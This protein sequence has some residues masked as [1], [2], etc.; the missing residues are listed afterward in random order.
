MC[1]NSKIRLKD[2]RI[3]KTDAKN[4]LL[5]GSTE[6]ERFFENSFLL[7]DSVSIKDFTEDNI[8]FI[9]GM[10]GT[11][12]TALLR[13]LEIEIRKLFPNCITSF[14][15]FKSDITEDTRDEFTVAANSF[16]TSKNID[17]KEFDRYLKVWEW[18]FYRQIV[19]LSEESAY[20]LFENDGNWQTFREFMSLPV[21]SKNKNWFSSL[22]IKVK[23]GNVK[24]QGGTEKLNVSLGLDFDVEPGKSKDV[25]F[26]KL[27]A[28]AHEL[29]V[30]LT[31][32]GYPLFI[33]VDE[34][35][36]SLTT[37]KQYKRDMSLVKDLVLSVSEFNRQCL[38]TKFP[39]KIIC[40]IRSEVIS[41]VESIGHELNKLIADFG[42]P[43]NWQRAGNDYRNHPLIKLV[44]KRIMASEEALGRVTSSS[45]EI[46]EKYFSPRFNNDPIQKYI[47]EQ[48]WER[49]RD[50]IRLLDISKK[51]FGNDTM[52]SQKVFEGIAKDYAKESWIE[53][54]EELSAIY[55]PEEVKG[56]MD[57]LMGIKCPFDYTDIKKIAE[58]KKEFYTEVESLL[59]KYRLP[60]I[61]NN[62][63]KVGIIGND[64]ERVRFSFRGDEGLLLEQPMK[65][66]NPLW[67]FLSVTRRQRN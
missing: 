50:I 62:L 24:I 37:T 56:I 63:Y 27:V 13:Y 46:W 33:F 66:V 14:I 8:F 3:G 35:E 31:T 57:L 61:L 32:T 41:A 52:F 7:P 54:S 43:L 20:P 19:R 60:D 48:T 64:G 30:N 67:K 40:G 55:R 5:N 12:K 36:V 4:E 22:G 2:L 23:H 65:I 11:G 49:P 25:N 45:D 38:Q 28:K 59:A 34:L 44:E 18:F 26:S 39:I 51:H 9:T 15:L 29:F 1:D 42:K 10:K 53:I 16:I 47:I 17:E 21:E 6:E 58:N